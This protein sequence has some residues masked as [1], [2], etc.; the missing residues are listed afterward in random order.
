MGAQ[1]K[2]RLAHVLLINVRGLGNEIAKNLVLAGIGSLTICD[3]YSVTEADL[4]AQFLLATPAGQGAEAVIG[5]NRAEAASEQLRALNPRVN[6]NIDTNSIETK[7]VAFFRKFT[8]V[9]ATDLPSKTLGFINTVT[10]FA[11]CP[12]YAASSYGMC[13]FIFADLIEHDFVI[14][15]EQSNIP[16]GKGTQETRTRSIVNVEAQ[17]P[18]SSGGAAKETVTKRE[19][20]S[21]WYLAADSAPLPSVIRNSP[22]R[23]RNVSPV[24]PCLRALW[25]YQEDHVDGDVPTPAEF[26]ALVLEK[27]KALGIPEVPQRTTDM[28][29]QGVGMSEISPI[30]SVLGG[31]LAQDVI[32]M[33]GQK[34]QPIQNLA[35]FDGTAMQSLVYSLHPDGNLGRNLLQTAPQVTTAEAAAASAS[36]LGTAP[37]TATNGSGGAPVLVTTGA[38][39]T[40]E[41]TNDL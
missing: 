27:Q 10:R 4:G 2:I 7:D 12:L 28:F 41:S 1:E 20:Y 30:V 14:V 25:A 34:Q 19:L 9:I 24:L 13:G 16:S 40:L 29:L 17:E 18:D 38:I 5:K 11:D 15:R 37:S 39:A 22:R 3:T 6:I 35:V 32:N 21:T 33:L 31:Q 26:A 23:L 36:L 8:I